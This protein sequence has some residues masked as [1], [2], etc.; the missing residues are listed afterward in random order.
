MNLRSLPAKPLNAIVFIAVALAVSSAQA[1]EAS[2]DYFKTGGVLRQPAVSEING[3][4]GY[5]GGVMNSYE[6]HNFDGSIS[7]PVSEQFGFQ[8]DAFYSRISDTD[9]GGGAGH[10]FWRDPNIGLLGI[11]GGYLACDGVDTFQAGAEGEY[12]LGRFTFGFFAGV[13]SI[14]Y[15]RSAPF[16]D[17]NPTRF[18]GRVSVDYYPVDD[19]RAGVSYINA[20]GENLVKG[21]LEYQTPLNGLAL[22]AEIARGDHDY[23][24]WLLGVR[25]YFG[26][27]KSLRDRQRQDDPPSLMPQILHGL[28]LYGAKF[29]H[30]GREYFNAHPDVGSW[31]NGYSE[32]QQILMEVTRTGNP[33][34]P[35]IPPTELSDMLGTNPPSMP[36]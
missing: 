36:E 9:F 19:L 7:F 31:G 17:T 2:Q 25:Y 21:E 28:G 26:G 20:F 10:L 27:S 16:I 32:Q 1:Q 23:D 14:S 34:Q 8:A 5:A 29:N 11:A 3:K 35:P 15:E 13:G 24:H 30:K 33:D 6:G 12:Y 4:L 18:V 22:T